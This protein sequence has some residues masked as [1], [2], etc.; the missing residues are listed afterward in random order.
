MKTLPGLRNSD[1]QKKIESLTMFMLA[2]KCI[3]ELDV[4]YWIKDPFS[5]GEN[6]KLGEKN[7]SQ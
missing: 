6:R 5:R 3:Y 1:C 7:S 2:S 4:L